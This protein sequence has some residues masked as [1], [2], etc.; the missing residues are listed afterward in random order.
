MIFRR[1]EPA[2]LPAL[3]ALGVDDELARSRA[4]RSTSAITSRW[5]AVALAR[6]DAQERL[7]WIRLT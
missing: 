2:D 3:V 4:S 6:G 1:A 7:R 5:P